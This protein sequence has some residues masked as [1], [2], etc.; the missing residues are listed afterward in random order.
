MGLWGCRV[1]FIGLIV[2]QPLWF[3]WI[4][5][6]TVVPPLLAVAL[7]TVPLLILLPFVWRLGRDALVV[8]GCVLLAYFC[9]GVSEAMVSPPSRVA[10]LIQIAL[11][12]MYFS[13]LASIRFGARR[14]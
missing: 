14:R 11:I 3:G 7:T 1:S 4:D 5:P 6:P 10:G 8:A 12:L 2:L 9:L 13:A